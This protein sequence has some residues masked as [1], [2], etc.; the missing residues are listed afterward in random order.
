LPN[1]TIVTTHGQQ[2]QA[3]AQ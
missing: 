1:P 2:I 3:W